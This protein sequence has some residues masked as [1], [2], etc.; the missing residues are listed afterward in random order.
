[1]Y[2]AYKNLRDC[3]FNS[4]SSLSSLNPK[5]KKIAENYLPFSTGIEIECSMKPGNSRKS[6]LIEQAMMCGNSLLSFNIQGSEEIDFRIPSG[7][8]GLITLENVCEKLKEFFLLNPASGIHYH[9][10]FTEHFDKLERR[11]FISNIAREIFLK[12][13]D[14]WGYVGNYNTR[15]VSPFKGDWVRF[16]REYKTIEFRIGEMSFDYKVLAKRIIHCNSM[17]EKFIK[18]LDS[19]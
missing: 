12:E 15:E 6:S 17:V 1:M 7:V 8:D 14:T 9:V 4:P 5:L 13:L 11:R 2:R 18:A 16:C 19:N 10:D 3:V